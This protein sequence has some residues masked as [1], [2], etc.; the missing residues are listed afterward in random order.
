VCDGDG[1]GWERVFLHPGKTR[2]GSPARALRFQATTSV[3]T[4]QLPPRFATISTAGQRGWLDISFFSATVQ[5]VVLSRAVLR[6]CGVAKVVYAFRDENV[7]PGKLFEEGVRLPK[8]VAT[9]R[10][11]RGVAGHPLVKS[12]SLV[13]ILPV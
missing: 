3:V 10:F 9:R 11:E 12:M 8:F 1:D 4:S 6:M 13:M 7:R 2:I 5:R